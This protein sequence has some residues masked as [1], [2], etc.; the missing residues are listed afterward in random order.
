[1][2]AMRLLHRAG[3]T[4]A[5]AALVARIRLSV[6]RLG[7]RLGRPFAQSASDIGDGDDD[8]GDDGDV[9]TLPFSGAVTRE[10]RSLSLSPPNNP[11]VH[12]SEAS[13]GINNPQVHLSEASGGINNPHAGVNGL[14][15]LLRAQRAHGIGIALLSA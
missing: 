11:Q 4:R 6:V 2:I 10:V 12:P 1:M 13:G 9:E 8:G 7:Q 14:S 15:L 3:E 5:L